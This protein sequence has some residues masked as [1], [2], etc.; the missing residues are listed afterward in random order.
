M[1]WTVIDTMYIQP[2]W[3]GAVPGL[4]LLE[5]TRLNIAIFLTNIYLDLSNHVISDHKLSLLGLT[6]SGFSF[7]YKY[8]VL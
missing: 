5:L 2:S 4:T 8:I 3:P 1:P 6:L 7:P